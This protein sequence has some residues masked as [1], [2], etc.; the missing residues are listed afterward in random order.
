VVAARANLRAG[1]AEA[2][3]SWLRRA[4][5]SGAPIDAVRADSELGPLLA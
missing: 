3:M 1:D 4:V 2:A 5:E